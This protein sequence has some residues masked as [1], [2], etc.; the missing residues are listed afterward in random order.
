MLKSI[1]VTNYLGKSIS[2]VFG[3]AEPESGLLI[4]EIDGLGPVKANINTTE[5]A[6]MDGSLFN[7]ARLTNR[8]LVISGLFTFAKTI[9]D[10]R[11]TSYK[12]FPIKQ[13]LIFQIE[14]DNRVATTTGYVETNEPDIFSEKSSFKISI[15]CESPYFQAKS[16]DI[17]TFAGVDAKF[18]FPYKNPHPT[19]KLTKFG[20]IV[21]KKE[22]SVYYNGD[23][24]TGCTIVIHAIGLVKNVKIYNIQTREVMSIDTDRLESLT[25]GPFDAGDTITVCTIEGKKSITLL[26]EGHTTNILNVLGKDVDWFKLAKGENLFTF[27]AEYGETNLQFKIISQVLYEGV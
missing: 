13:P 3:E 23:A 8:N 16:K 20:E 22:R 26:R 6:T 14:T 12:Y 21:Y 9:E 10:A 5:L 27:V 18:K 19:K 1:T 25:G 24:E 17:T 4:T 11:L 15:V 7:S 2:Y